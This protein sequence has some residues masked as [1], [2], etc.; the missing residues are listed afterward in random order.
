[1]RWRDARAQAASGRRPPLPVTMEHCATAEVRSAVS[2]FDRRSA[3]VG[4]QGGREPLSSTSRARAFLAATQDRARS[5]VATR[6]RA[7]RAHAGPAHRRAASRSPSRR[8]RKTRKRRHRQ[9]TTRSDRM[10]LRSR[11]AHR[12]ASMR[13]VDGPTLPW[14]LISTGGGQWYPIN[15]LFQRHEA[16]KRTIVR[17]Q[18]FGMPY[19]AK[20]HVLSCLSFCLEW[21]ISLKRAVKVSHYSPCRKPV[22]PMGQFSYS[23]AT[24][25]IV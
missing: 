20:I 22:D 6:C 13:E 23:G 14:R 8:A 9:W 25:E 16:V 11:R 4:V 17:A 15:P 18:T 21:I 3:L 5:L 10:W 24:W 12:R 7:A 19:V 2:P 1:M